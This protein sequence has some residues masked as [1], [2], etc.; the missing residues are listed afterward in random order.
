MWI[1][2]RNHKR[3]RVDM[4]PNTGNNEKRVAILV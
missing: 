4:V 1:M 3:L 2:L